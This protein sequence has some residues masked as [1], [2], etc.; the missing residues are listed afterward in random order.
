M[1]ATI[2]G[3]QAMRDALH[4]YTESGRQKAASV[5]RMPG[6][7]FPRASA[8]LTFATLG[9]T[10]Q[11]QKLIAELSKDYPSDTVIRYTV[12]PSVQRP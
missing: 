8:A 10:A 2:L 11:A 1:P 12:V 9:D 7:F 4:G 3:T 5:Q 6:D